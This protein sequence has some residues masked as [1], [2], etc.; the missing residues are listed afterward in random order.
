M[1][2]DRGVKIDVRDN[3]I[4]PALKALKKLMVKTGLFQ[5]MKRRESYEKPSVKRK[6]KQAQARKKLRKAMKRAQPRDDE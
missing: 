2:E 6:R 3:Q 5:E 1:R 4:E